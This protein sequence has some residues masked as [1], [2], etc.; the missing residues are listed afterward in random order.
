MWLY[1]E[2]LS[3]EDSWIIS[4]HSQIYSRTRDLRRFGQRP[5]YSPPT[6]SVRMMLNSASKAPLYF[7]PSAFIPVTCIFRRRTSK[8]YVNVCDIDPASAPHDS[9]RATLLFPGGVIIPRS[10]S[11]AAK[12]IPVARHIEYSAVAHRMRPMLQLTNI[13]SHSHRSGDQTSVQGARTAFVSHHL[14]CHPP[15]RHI[16]L[17][18]RMRYI[19]RSRH[20]RCHRC[21]RRGVISRCERSFRTCGSCLQRHSG[22]YRC[23]CNRK[24]RADKIKGVSCTCAWLPSMSLG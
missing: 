5:L 17:C 23:S 24:S 12:L 21:M 3:L 2:Q 15:N 13:W 20:C 11:Y 9:F 4:H 6:P 14:H 7:T 10:A 8:G 1:L 22:R 19:S 16:S 18:K